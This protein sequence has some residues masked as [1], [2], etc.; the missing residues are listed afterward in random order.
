MTKKKKKNPE[1]ITKAWVSIIQKLSFQFL[2]VVL[3]WETSV[4]LEKICLQ[5]ETPS[6][7]WMM[8][9][10]TLHGTYTFYGH[11]RWTQLDQPPKWAL[12]SQWI[13]LEIKPLVSKQLMLIPTNRT[14]LRD[15][16]QESMLF[17]LYASLA[18]DCAL[19]MSKGGQTAW[20]SHNLV[21]LWI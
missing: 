10:Q 12:E 3:W 4:H 19:Q 15:H 20:E 6:L 2:V 1:I 13:S 5:Q 9:N 16:T 18:T 11:H 7:R 14:M 21:F 8:V 17:L